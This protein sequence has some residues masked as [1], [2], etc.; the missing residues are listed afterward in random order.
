MV[1]LLFISFADVTV[2]PCSLHATRLC[3]SSRSPTDQCNIPA[4]LFC[5]LLEKKMAIESEA[6]R[7]VH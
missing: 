7:L 1:I 6:Q 3:H 4:S 5:L 2:S